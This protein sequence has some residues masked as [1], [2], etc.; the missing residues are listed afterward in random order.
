MQKLKF[1]I[2]YEKSIGIWNFFIGIYTESLAK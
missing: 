2:P 1:Q